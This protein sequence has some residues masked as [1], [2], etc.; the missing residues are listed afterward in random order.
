[1]RT[2]AIS[3]INRPPPKELRPRRCRPRPEPHA[4]A[5]RVSRTP[6]TI[7]RLILGY[8]FVQG[9]RGNADDPSITS[10]RETAGPAEISNGRAGGLPNLDESE[11]RPTRGEST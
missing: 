7:S 1:M 11:S 4:S 8:H 2:S 3:R 9:V 6:S 10:R 5:L